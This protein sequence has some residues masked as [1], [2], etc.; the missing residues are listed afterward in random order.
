MISNDK[1]K[2]YYEKRDIIVNKMKKENNIIKYILLQTQL[3]KLQK[4]YNVFT[5]KRSNK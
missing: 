2:K 4:N 5:I 3:K 1:I